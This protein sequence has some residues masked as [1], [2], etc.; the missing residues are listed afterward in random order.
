MAESNPT[1]P[2][3][4]DPQ[5]VGLPH[6]NS[7]DSPIASDAE[8]SEDWFN[9]SF[10]DLQLTP[11]KVKDDRWSGE[12]EAEQDETSQPHRRESPGSSWS[13]TKRG[14]TKGDVRLAQ[15]RTKEKRRESEKGGAAG[16][17]ALDLPGKAE[18]GGYR[19]DERKP[20]PQ[21]GLRAQAGRSNERKT[22]GM[23]K[24]YV[25]LTLSVDSP[26]DKRHTLIVED[27]RVSA[28]ERGTG[29]DDEVPDE[30]DA[31]WFQRNLKQLPTIFNWA[32]V[33]RVTAA[34]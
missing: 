18:D 21:E 13:G 9:R 8:P 29:E 34:R 4:A 15:K 26:S 31:Y 22:R 11:A 5:T 7:E 30:R 12:D 19:P 20:S 16:C 3:W 33:Y 2:N 17:G 27:E 6:K 25:G 28:K 10:D 23:D 24:N 14:I 1:A 32:Q